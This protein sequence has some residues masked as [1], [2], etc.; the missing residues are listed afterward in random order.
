[1][2]LFL[3]TC[4][5]AIAQVGTFATPNVEEIKL[6]ETPAPE[7][8]PGYR[9]LTLSIDESKKQFLATLVNKTDNPYIDS[10]EPHKKY[11]GLSRRIDSCNV[12]IYEA[13]QALGSIE[14]RDNRKMTCDIGVEAD[15]IVHEVTP[16]MGDRRYL[17]KP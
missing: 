2:R 15:I 1:M 4:L 16:E 8:N 6:Y 12:L 13:F 3:V 17:S 9:L 11:Y 14:I 7:F 10:V 5:I